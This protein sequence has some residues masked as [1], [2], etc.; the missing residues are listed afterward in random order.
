MFEAHVR[1]E[2]TNRKLTISVEK[3]PR[4][5]A[6]IFDRSVIIEKPSTNF[7]T[8]VCRVR[9]EEFTFNTGDW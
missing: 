4:N 6:A 3:F 9:D 2:Q 7:V 1:V 5:A 8:Y